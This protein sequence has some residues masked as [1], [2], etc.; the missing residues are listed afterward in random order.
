MM[1][2]N[3]VNNT[4]TTEPPSLQQPTHQTTLRYLSRLVQLCDITVTT[5][6]SYLQIMKL[7]REVQTE[8]THDL[9]ALQGSRQFGLLAVVL[10]DVV[11]ALEETQT[12]MNR[13]ALL[14][15]C[16]EVGALTALLHA[17]DSI[18]EVV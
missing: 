6:D 5:L 13:T 4:N 7:V 9:T 2:T 18:P 15:D 3:G 16:G 14:E 8:A 1:A 10:H 17:V 12:K 11:E